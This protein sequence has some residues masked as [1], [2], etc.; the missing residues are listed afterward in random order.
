MTDKDT[1][2]VA[3][4]HCIEE[5]MDSVGITAEQKSNIYRIIAA[6]L[7]IGN[8]NFQ[9]STKD[10]KGDFSFLGVLKLINFLVSH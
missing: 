2:D 7:H 9:E 1:D 10:K 6:V 5:A 4:F 3:D 8:I